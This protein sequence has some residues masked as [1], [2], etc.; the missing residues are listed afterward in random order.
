MIA[1]K[2]YETSQW[3]WFIHKQLPGFSLSIPL[4]SGLGDLSRLSYQYSRRVTIR[5]GMFLCRRLQI[6]KSSIYRKKELSC[7]KFRAVAIRKYGFPSSEWP[8]SIWETLSSSHILE[9]IFH[10]PSIPFI[11]SVEGAI[12]TAWCQNYLS[13]HTNNLSCHSA[14]DLCIL[15]R[16]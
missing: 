2:Q 14:F 6:C 16:N 9:G 5:V 12:L 3:S 10:N 1:R 13:S 15:G 11:D 4:P 8:E 7:G